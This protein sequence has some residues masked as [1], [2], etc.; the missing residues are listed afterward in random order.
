MS[1]VVPKG[2]GW[3]VEIPYR[4]SHKHPPSL[5]P[6]AW[7]RDS[8]PHFS[9]LGSGANHSATSLGCLKG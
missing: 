3:K 8:E 1:A 5:A 4:Q 6:W 7:R 9:D 2:L